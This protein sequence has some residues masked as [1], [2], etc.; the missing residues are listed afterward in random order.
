M[1]STRETVVCVTTSLDFRAISMASTL[2]VV[3]CILSLRLWLSSDCWRTWLDKSFSTSAQRCSRIRARSATAAVAEEASSRPR[4]KRASRLCQEVS[5]SLAKRAMWFSRPTISSRTAL[6][7]SS[8]R[9]MR[10]SWTWRLCAARAFS[11]PETLVRRRSKLAS[12]SLSLTCWATSAAALSSKRCSNLFAASLCQFHCSSFLACSACTW[13][14]MPCSKRSTSAR[15]WVR[16]LRSDSSWAAC[17]SSCDPSWCTATSRADLSA[18]IAC[19]N[20]ST[21]ISMSFSPTSRCCVSLVMASSMRSLLS[22][23][24]WLAC[25]RLCRHSSFTPC[26]CAVRVATWLLIDAIWSTTTCHWNCANSSF[27]VSTSVFFCSISRSAATVM[28]ACRGCRPSRR[29]AARS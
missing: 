16:R 8:P 7:S 17:C 9:R 23:S 20:L 29:A 6:L 2:V 22:T 15:S 4:C 3:T 10:S 24:S 12:T 14:C 27:L 18:Q 26:S 11:T 21:F 19:T 28:E 5:N 13:C 25:C 1:S